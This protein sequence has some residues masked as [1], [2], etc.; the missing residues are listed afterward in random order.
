MYVDLV[1]LP[2]TPAEM[3]EFLADNSPGAYERVV[4]RL[5]A[6]PQYGERWGRHWM[7][8]WRYS[9]WDG[10]AAEVR[11]S[12]P[13]IWRW[14]DWIIESLNA[15]KPYDRM[16]VEMLAADELSPL[17]PDALR[18]TG[19]LVRNWYR[20]NRNVWLE[21]TVEHTSK[22]FLG[23][24]LNCARC[25][26]HM[27]DPIL[28]SEYYQFRAVFE[29]HDVRDDRVPGQRDTK[30][31]AL[32]R[33]FDADAARPTFLFA[34]GNEAKP[35]KEHPLVS[36]G[37]AR[38][39][40]WPTGMRSRSRCPRRRTIPAC[41]ASCKTR[42]WPMPGPKSLGRNGPWPKPAPRW[43]KP[44][45]SSPALPRPTCANAPKEADA[46]NVAAEDAA[47][48]DAPPVP[49]TASPADDA[50]KTETSESALCA[51]VDEAQSAAAMAEHE[52]LAAAAS[53]VAVRAKI[54]ADNAAF[55]TPPAVDA[56]E[57]AREASR[58]E[59]VANAQQSQIDVL[60]LEHELALARAGDDAAKKKIAT[61]E[62][63]LA[64]ARKTREAAQVAL[65][66]PCGH[67]SAL[68][69]G[70]SHDHQRAPRGAGTLDRVEAESA[71]RTGGD[72]PHLD[73]PF[74]QPIGGQRVRLRTQRQTSDASGI[75]RLAGRR[76]DGAGLAHEGHPSAVG[77]QRRLSNAIGR[78]R[79]RPTGPPIPRTSSCGG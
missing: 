22:A 34:R 77:H 58:A 49:A 70:L 73:A 14:R 1:G 71:D 15:D 59:R 48:K 25:H 10:Y 27:Y 16:I 38:V 44:V 66:A 57:L 41:A 42:R 69:R 9:D 20:F 72:Q 12:K 78:R 60:R 31:D 43:P 56:K 52:V 50:K 13:H 64:E 45:R 39:R 21:A 54:A 40:R 23:V 28:Q 55:A 24:T 17:D 65:G 36:R 3:A 32:V 2:P 75:A 7:D 51:A 61:I 4:D 47:A 67:V 46:K 63:K 29:P 6:S 53:L 37:A 30:R 35:D 33:V 76:A 8:V 11:E 79:A 18:A 26:D 19:F 74:R 5:L 68:W 62:P